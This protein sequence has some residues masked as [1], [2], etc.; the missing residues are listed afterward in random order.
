MTDR[1]S[2]RV[3]FRMLA[4][5]LL[6]LL[7]VAP[8]AHSV[9]PAAAQVPSP[10][11]DIQPGV[12][13][14]DAD[15]VIEGIRL[16]QDFFVERVGA[17]M[18]QALEVTIHASASDLSAHNVAVAQ[19]NR[20]AVYTGSIGWQ[21][22]APAERLAVIVHEY[23]HFYQY[24]MLGSQDF[25]SPAWLDEGIAEYLSVLALSE[26]GII[27]RADF[28][29]YW[30]LL[31]DRNPVSQSLAELEAWSVYQ[32]A[33]GA[34]Y[35]LSYFSI[36][37]LMET[38][39]LHAMNAYYALIA[40]GTSFEQAFAAAFGLSPAE[41]YAA[42]ATWDGLPTANGMPEDISVFVP[43]DRQESVEI[44]SAPRALFPDEQIFVHGLTSPGT[45][46]AIGLTLPGDMQPI[47][48]RQ[49]F[50]DGTGDVHWLLTVPATTPP[51]LAVLEMHCGGPSISRAAIVQ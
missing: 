2:S 30:A 50:A 16:A 4:A 1:N 37:L 42:F 48:A 47:V 17:T 18:N 26:P 51:G 14:T 9:A 32:N 15:F 12:S 43:V 36:A 44:V 35:P 22:S 11:F 23:T 19:R 7:V 6:A 8:V 31:L 46:C 21:Q 3:L 27:D 29:A 28:D 49:T 13:E 40:G 24:L 45:T 38:R 33:E 20:I 39:D 25:R 5:V 10:S 34:L 41:H